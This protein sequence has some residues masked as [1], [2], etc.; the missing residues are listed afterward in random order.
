MSDVAVRYT[1]QIDQRLAELLDA[2]DT[3]AT[4]KEAMNYSVVA[5]GKRLRPTLNIMANALLD[6][7]LKETLDLSL[8]HI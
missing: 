6:G 5:G 4:I 1:K 8:I 3:N 7:N 2:T